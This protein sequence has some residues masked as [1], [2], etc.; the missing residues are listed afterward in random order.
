MP[1]S[2]SYMQKIEC[3]FY[4][5]QFRAA[6]L[7]ANSEVMANGV[8]VCKLKVAVSRELLQFFYFRNQTLLGP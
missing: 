4:T 2:S 7:Y 3:I 6:V 8:F 5:C 1:T